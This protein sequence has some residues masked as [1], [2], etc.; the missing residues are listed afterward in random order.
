MKFRVIHSGDCNYNKDKAEKL[1]KLGF[2]FD[3]MQHT[4][5]KVITEWYQER[6]TECEP[7]D[8]DEAVKDKDVVE[9]KLN[10]LEDLM[11]F[12]NEYG[13]IVV[14]QPKE[15]LPIIEIYDDYRE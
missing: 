5:G 2:K 3:R 10:S 4:E 9:I 15:G 7:G 12:I 14:S 11:D 13:E 1:E 6:E 8:Y